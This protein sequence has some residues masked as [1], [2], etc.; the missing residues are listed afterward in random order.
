MALRVMV[1]DDALLMRNMLKDIPVREEIRS[2][3]FKVW[4]EVLAGGAVRVA[5]PAQHAGP[6]AGRCWRHGHGGFD[7]VDR[8]PRQVRDLG[9]RLRARPELAD[10]PGAGTIYR[11]KGRVP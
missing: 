3:L 11:F 5:L 2:F 6:C 7:L 8:W 9:Q 1:V 10:E 4:A